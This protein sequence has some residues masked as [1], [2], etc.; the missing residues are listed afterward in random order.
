MTSSLKEM[1]VSRLAKSPAVSLAEK[2]NKKAKKPSK[3]LKESKAPVAKKAI[4]LKE[5]APTKPVFNKTDKATFKGEVVM[6]ES[7]V[8]GTEA[9]VPV[10]RKNGQIMMVRPGSLKGGQNLNEAWI[11]NI[12]FT[13]V[14]KDPNSAPEFDLTPEDLGFASAATASLFEEDDDKGSKKPWKAEKDHDN[15]SN[16]RHGEDDTE[17]DNLPKPS[18]TIATAYDDKQ[19]PKSQ[20]TPLAVEPGHTVATDPDLNAFDQPGDAPDTPHAEMQDG[21][22]AASPNQSSGEAPDVE[23]GKKDRVGDHDGVADQGKVE[24]EKLSHEKGADS[25]GSEKDSG[26]A[27][28]KNPAMESVKDTKYFRKAEGHGKK[29]TKG[30]GTKEDPFTNE[31]LGEAFE[32]MESPEGSAGGYDCIRITPAAL[33]AVVSTLVQRQA[34]VTLMRAVVEALS[35]HCHETGAEIDIADLETIAAHVNGEEHA[36]AADKAD[37]VVGDDAVPVPAGDGEETDATDGGEPGKTKLMAS[38]GGE[39]EPDAGGDDFGS[40]EPAPPSEDNKVV[41]TYFFDVLRDRVVESDEDELRI[42]KRRIGQKYW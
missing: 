40:D 27:E 5:M 17:V 39:S 38:E 30:T 13:Y 32:G 12:P 20:G 33:A 6:L 28:E 18:D 26:N 2:V 31:K 15:G 34:D 36:E 42:I 21:G 7:A 19:A 8:V 3:A 41:E 35:E 29:N 10:R 23:G 14:Y 4:P 24:G 37:G 1:I 22:N 9:L 16:I 11:A 25:N